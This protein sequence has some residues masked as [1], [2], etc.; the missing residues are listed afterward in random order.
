MAYINIVK[1][2]DTDFLGNQYLV[3]KFNT[4][5]DLV[6]FKAIFKLGNFELV[7]PD[8]T[9]KYLEIVLSKEVTSSLPK[10][11]L[12][13]TLQL[14]DTQERVRT[15]TTVL[16]FNIVTKVVAASQVS[17]NSIQLDVK[18]DKNE[19]TIDMNIVGLSKVVA[20]GYLK[21]M[22]DYNTYLDSKILEVK[23]LE[24]RIENS[25]KETLD[26]RNLAEE[27]AESDAVIGA[28][29]H[30]AKYYS[31]SAKQTLTQAQQ[32]Y[33]NVVELKNASSEFLHNAEG[34]FDKALY[35]SQITNCILE[36]PQRI[37][38]ELVDGTLTIKAGSVVIIPYGVE[39]KTIEFPTGSVFLNDNFKVVSTQWDGS[40]FY[41]WAELQ[42]DVSKASTDADYDLVV[43]F[44]ID[45]AASEPTWDLSG[46]Y[47][48]N[49]ASGTT[50]PTNYKV[51]YNTGTNLVYATT[52]T[53]LIYT[54]PFMITTGAFG[55]VKQVF[56]GF[57]YIGS[58]I[59]VD[60]GVKGLI[61]NG[62]NADGSLNNIEYV[63]KF[64]T[65]TKV[66]GNTSRG[67]L[68]FWGISEPLSYFQDRYTFSVKNRYEAEAI[69]AIHPNTAHLIYIEDENVHIVQTG[70]EVLTVSQ[71]LNVTFDDS[72]NVVS[73][74]QVKQPPRIAEKSM[75]DGQWVYLPIS[76]SYVKWSASGTKT[77][78]LSS[79]LPN[80]GYNYECLFGIDFYAT[81]QISLSI[82]TDLATLD[83]NNPAWVY[84][85]GAGKGNTGTII[86]AVGSGR[87]VQVNASAAP[88]G[89][90]YHFAMRGYRRL[91]TNV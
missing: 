23:E 4:D 26:Y 49:C 73:F 83:S 11:K 32:V 27:W 34:L 84:N 71:V 46:G 21:Q 86:L 55:S 45:T 57:G 24:N 22:E 87:Y 89:G 9:A 39:D 68:F 33:E 51:Y 42:N 7:Y 60:K 70:A 37:K 76:A 75:V 82:G 2:D 81:N 67:N 59:W 36:M 1:G 19:L 8:L 43:Q 30:S 88:T 3:V 15:I 53:P 17:K 72:Y 44:R 25:S 66:D 62:R 47:I 80:D 69:Q 31:N 14:I 58:T 64:V 12:Y 85:Q 74:S 79:I 90:T 54:L 56:N 28:D 20:E 41:V 91:G 65:Y 35:K 6:G 18:I 77:I 29:G 48:Q 63:G 78:D 13:G 52:N 61:P 5:L 16:P 40:S 50:P 10:G 38:Y